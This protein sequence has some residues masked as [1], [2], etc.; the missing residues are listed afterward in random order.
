[1]KDR[2]ASKYDGSFC[3]NDDEPEREKV[4]EE[5]E[6]PA[7]EAEKLRVKQTQVLE[8]PKKTPTEKPAEQED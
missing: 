5:P 4:E 3:R 7:V 6:S 2:E 8:G 1:M